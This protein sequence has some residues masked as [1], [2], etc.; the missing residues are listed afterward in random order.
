[1]FGIQTQVVQDM[2][3]LQ[4]ICAGWFIHQR[5]QSACEATSDNSSQGTFK[6][7]L[8]ITSFRCAQCFRVFPEG[9]FYE[10]EGRKYCER[11]FQV[12]F[13]PCCGKCGKLLL[14]YPQQNKKVIC[15]SHI[16]VKKK[17]KVPSSFV[18]LI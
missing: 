4:L 16:K 17:L 1:M 5:G 6:H 8:C 9:I 18:T 3:S 12:L 13:A 11:D 15:N 10:F 7:C 14:H 2:A